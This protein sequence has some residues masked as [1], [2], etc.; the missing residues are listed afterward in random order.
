MLRGLAVG[1]QGDAGREIDTSC[2]AGDV[3]GGVELADVAHV[4][5]FP[6]DLFQS[7]V[8]SHLLWRQVPRMAAGGHLETPVS[9]GLAYALDQVAFPSLAAFPSESGS[10]AST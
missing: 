8:A 4:V 3:V 1:A 9:D 6:A 5:G 2:L 7:L 10:E